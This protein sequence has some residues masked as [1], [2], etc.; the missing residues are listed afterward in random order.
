MNTGNRSLTLIWG[1][2]TMIHT[3]LPRN[4]P[5]KVMGP[6]EESKDFGAKMRLTR[7]IDWPTACSPGSEGGSFDPT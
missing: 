5:A 6:T 1:H 2:G 3:N 4:R 7:K